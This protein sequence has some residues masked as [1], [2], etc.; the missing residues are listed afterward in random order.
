M[1]QI[2]CSDELASGQWARIFSVVL[3]KEQLA[4]NRSEEFLKS[5]TKYLV[6]HFEEGSI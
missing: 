4:F 2:Q 6:S 1:L 3:E 5:R